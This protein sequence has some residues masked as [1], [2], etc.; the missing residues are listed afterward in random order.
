[1]SD[2]GQSD[3]DLLRE[4]KAIN[5]LLRSIRFLLRLGC[6]VLFGLFW[7]NIDKRPFSVVVAAISAWVV[8]TLISAFVYVWQDFQPGNQE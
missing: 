1:M 6:S 5:R 2:V 8:L 3:S 4:L 7:Q